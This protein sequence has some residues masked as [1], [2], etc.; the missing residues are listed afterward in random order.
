MTPLQS[1]NLALFLVLFSVAALFFAV[2]A[3]KYE[4][5]F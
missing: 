2:A 3:S 4:T 5:I 1:K